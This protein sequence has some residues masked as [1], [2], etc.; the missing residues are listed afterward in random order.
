MTTVYKAVGLSVL[1][2]TGLATFA[3]KGAVNVWL[4]DPANNV[5]F[6]Q[7]TQQPAFAKKQPG[8][9]PLPLMT[10]QSTKR[11]MALAGP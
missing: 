2:A 4:T 11:L 5:F 3:Q 9:I 1:L 10:D 8:K 7:Q 6:Q